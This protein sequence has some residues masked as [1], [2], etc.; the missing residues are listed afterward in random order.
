MIGAYGN[1]IDKRFVSNFF[2]VSP[3]QTCILLGV[4]ER[5]TY[6]DRFWVGW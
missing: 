5:N 2:T 1:D 4:V 6:N 3:T